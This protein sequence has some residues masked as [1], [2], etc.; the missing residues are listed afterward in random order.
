MGMERAKVAVISGRDAAFLDDQFWLDRQ[1]VSAGK[2]RSDA[3]L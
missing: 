1:A 2:K 3:M